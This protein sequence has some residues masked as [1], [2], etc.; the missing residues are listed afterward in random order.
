MLIRDVGGG[1][2]EGLVAIV[3]PYLTI[4]DCTP[5]AYSRDKKLRAFIRILRLLQIGQSFC[6]IVT[7][8]YEVVLFI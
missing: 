5:L 8:C 1:V 7:D 6:G 4:R 3:G 2:C